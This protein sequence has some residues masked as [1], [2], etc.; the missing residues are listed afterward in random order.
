M[1]LKV[2]ETQARAFHSSKLEILQ[3]LRTILQRTLSKVGAPTSYIQDLEN[4]SIKLEEHVI[5]DQHMLEI[6]RYRNASKLSKILLI[7]DKCTKKLQEIK[8][9]IL[10]TSTWNNDIHTFAQHHKSDL[11]SLQIFIPQ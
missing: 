6:T 7:K 5:I 1:D 4:K 9:T 10:N 8:F 11:Q 3:N 2:L